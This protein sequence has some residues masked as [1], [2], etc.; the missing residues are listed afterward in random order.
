MKFGASETELSLE[1]IIEEA[2]TERHELLP[3]KVS[4]GGGTKFGRI[5]DLHG[6][7]EAELPSKLIIKEAPTKGHEVLLWKVSRESGMKFGASEAKLPLKPVIEEA[8]IEWHELLPQKI[9]QEDG[10]QF[11]RIHD[12]PAQ[13]RLNSP[14]SSSS[15]KPR[16]RGMKFFH[17]RFYGKAE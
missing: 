7:S 6:A 5:H 13:A 10:M 4:Q 16:Q 15:R 14:R 12:I 8:P 2:P 1:P 3:Q 9:S 11:S 17:G